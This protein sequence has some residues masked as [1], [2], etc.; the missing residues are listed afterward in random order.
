M[1]RPVGNLGRLFKWIK[2]NSLVSF[3]SCVLGILLIIG[4][5]VFFTSEIKQSVVEGSRLV[6]GGK[7]PEAIRSYER[8]RVLLKWVP[9]SDETVAHVLSSMG[10]AWYGKGDQQTAIRFYERALE[11]DPNHVPALSGMGDVYFE[12]G[13]Y[14]QTIALYDKAL[15]LSPEDRNSYY[16]R[17]RAY[18]EQGS[19]RAALQDFHRAIRITPDDLET[20]KEIP[21]LLLNM[22]LKSEASR[23]AYLQKEGFNE[24]EIKAILQLKSR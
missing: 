1:A 23:A 3:F 14:K 24:T 8:A 22:G 10:D 19:Y 16:Q 13:L 9:F 6:D 7:Y 5:Y 17:G 18:K 15:S 11:I 2:R 12:M 21:S 4:A 20:L